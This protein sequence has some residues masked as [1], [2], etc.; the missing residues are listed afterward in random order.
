MNLQHIELNFALQMV[1]S[2][3]VNKSAN[4]SNLE[5]TAPNHFAAHSVRWKDS[6]VDK[7]ELHLY[8]SI[9]LLFCTVAD[10]AVAKALPSTPKC[11]PVARKYTQLHNRQT[12]APATHNKNQ[13]TTT[14]TNKTKWNNEQMLSSAVVALNFQMTN[15]VSVVC[16]CRYVYYYRFALLCGFWFVNQLCPSLYSWTTIFICRLEIGGTL[17][18]NSNN[19]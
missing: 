11:T 9:N 6:I 5:N 3:F 15:V 16:V 17:P 2:A 14:T 13:T 8:V 7:F 1:I 12:A 18:R 19:E 4:K 10:P